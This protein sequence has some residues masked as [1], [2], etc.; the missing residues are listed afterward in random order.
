MAQEDN[1]KFIKKMDSM[2]DKLDANMADIHKNTYSTTKEL[3][4]ATNNI[5]QS[6]D[7]ELSKF[8]HLDNDI[9]QISNITQIYNRLIQKNGVTNNGEK[10]SIGDS[11][12]F[13]ND[14]NMFSNVLDAYGEN[15]NITALDNEYDICCKYMPKLQMALDLK[16]DNVL[17]ADNFKKEYINAVNKSNHTE[18]D[19]SIF[20]TRLK[21]IIKRYNLE[22]LFEDMVDDAYKY[23]ECFIYNVPYKKAFDDLLARKQNNGFKLMETTVLE[24]G[25]I[26]DTFEES[27]NFRAKYKATLEQT[28]LGENGSGL[29][30]VLHKTGI[31]ESVIEEYA[32]V[33][34]LIN[35]INES[36]GSSLYESYIHEVSNTNKP[37][38]KVKFDK[39]IGDEL[40]FDGL[41]AN[42]G[43][44]NKSDKRENEKVKNIPGFVIRK[45]ERS[46]IIPIY[47]ED[48]CLGYYYLEMNNSMTDEANQVIMNGS[49]QMQG[50]GRYMGR[51]KT[52]SQDMIIQHLSAQ[53]SEHI[54]AHFINTNQDLR[55]EIYTI[56]KYNDTC[57]ITRQK[58]DLNV[59][60]FPAE[61]VLHFAFKKDPKTHRGIS[62]I[63]K[64]LIPAKL[65]I[66][67]T[68]CNAIGILTR[69]QDKRVYYVKQQVETNVHKTLINVINQ[70]Q[71]GNFGIRQME[72]INNILGIIGRFNDHVIPVG[73]SGESPV[74]MEVLQGQDIKTNDDFLAQLEENAI[75]STD[76]PLELVNAIRGIDYAVHYT[77]SNSKFLKIVYKDQTVCEHA[78]STLLTRIY[79]SEYEA[80]DEIELS[81][82]APSFL[83]MTNG[84]NLVENAKS[85]INAILEVDMA[86]EDDELRNSVARKLLRH[87]LPNHIDL[88]TFDK[89]KNIARIEIETTKSGNSEE[90]NNE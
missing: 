16:R 82:P 8:N 60:F 76:V 32:R 38:K 17:S 72:S 63:Y 87:F 11:I 50:K 57:N 13:F 20:S 19:E 59:S 33:D 22:N 40:S 90:D 49:M 42:D 26:S 25:I 2:I 68:Q 53:I 79:N 71:K 1:E 31:Y 67:I 65:W 15:R 64:G 47:I 58:A 18:E 39:L 66:C 44:I 27:S 51:E 88:E 62:S 77:M 73:P 52:N 80:N 30:I 81:L 36:Y 24:N 21:D 28:S 89:I 3:N 12:N 70:L 45:L 14:A 61:D 55:K 35:S 46:N 23:G 43:L 9:T 86:N 29:R 56:L 74:N 4:N 85:Y 54:N 69:S 78:F 48:I 5:V 10:Q 34:K 41:E 7:D 6:I 75:G 83:S 84:A 37:T